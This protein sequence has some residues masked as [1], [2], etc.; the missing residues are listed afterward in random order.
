[1]TLSPSQVKFKLFSVWPSLLRGCTTSKISA[2]HEIY[3][4]RYSHVMILLSS[5]GVVAGLRFCHTVVV[6]GS[7]SPCTPIVI[8]S[9]SSP[10]SFLRYASEEETQRYASSWLR[11]GAG[12]KQHQSEGIL[13]LC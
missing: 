5:L 11:G 3:S 4:L 9:A 8:L 12:R 13:A 1:M 7:R 6:C 10:T 2:G